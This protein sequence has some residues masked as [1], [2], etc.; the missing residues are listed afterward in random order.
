MAQAQT[1]APVGVPSLRLVGR[2]ENVK[3]ISTAKGL[4][5]AHLVKL[6]A[7]DEYSSPATVRVM[8]ENRCGE[9]GTAFDQLVQVGGYGRTYQTTD[10]E[11]GRKVNVPT[12]DNTLTV[13][14]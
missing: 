5:F 14:G 12:A 4:M 7:A 1:A 8:S 11:T 10:E 6:R 13:I 3:R 9:P 2:I